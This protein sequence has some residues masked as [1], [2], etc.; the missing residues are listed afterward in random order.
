MFHIRV[1]GIVALQGAPCHQR[2]D[3]STVRT[4]ATSIAIGTL[5]EQVQI[6]IGRV[7]LQI[8]L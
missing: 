8:A 5:R 7:T 4:I 2:V 6:V 1:A 3:P